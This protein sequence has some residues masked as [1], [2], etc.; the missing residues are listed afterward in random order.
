M[1]VIAYNFLKATYD[2]PNNTLNIHRTLKLSNI[3]Y[4]YSLKFRNS[5]IG[6][7]LLIPFQKWGSR[8]PKIAVQLT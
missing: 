1:K 3:F 6:M 7:L 8:K 4:L 2:I 5:G